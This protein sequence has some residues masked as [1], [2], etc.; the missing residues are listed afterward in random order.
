MSYQGIEDLANNQGGVVI[1][2]QIGLRSDLSLDLQDA[3][4]YYLLGV[5]LSDGTIHY[6][7]RKNAPEIDNRP[8]GGK[9]LQAYIRIYQ[10]ATEAKQEFVNYLEN[11]FKDYTAKVSRRISRARTASIKGRRIN[12]K[13]LVAI[14]IRDLN[15]VTK[16]IDLLPQLSRILI[17]N[18][19]LALHFLA[20]Y[21]DGD[22]SY[23]KRTISISAGKVEMFSYL[24]CTLLALGTAYKVYRNRDNYVIEFRDNILMTKLSSLCQRLNIPIPPERLYGDKLLLASSL[25][26][27][28]LSCPDLT[29]YAKKDKMINFALYTYLESLYT[30]KINRF[31]S[32]CYDI[33]WTNHHIFPLNIFNW[34]INKIQ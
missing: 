15:F 2:T 14:T 18:P 34:Y 21:L 29:S 24:I 3:N 20:G 16:V 9:Y 26:G 5:I 23:N 30:S 32:N 22:G 12:G 28:N 7:K 31:Y 6:R 1:P 27:G 8:R 4:F 11:S 33:S 25:V 13:D 19:Y 17:G 10:S